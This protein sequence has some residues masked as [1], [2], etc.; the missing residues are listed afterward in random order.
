M[1]SGRYCLIRD[2][3]LVK[4]GKGLR[5]HEVLIAFSVRA[6]WQRLRQVDFSLRRFKP[7]AELQAREILGE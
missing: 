6:V 4:G 3:G 7:A 5:H 2:L 1:S